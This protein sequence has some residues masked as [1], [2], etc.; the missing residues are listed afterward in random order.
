MLTVRHYLLDSL[1][2]KNN[3]KDYGKL[4]GSESRLSSTSEVTSYLTYT[5]DK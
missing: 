2:R 5:V 4:A 1:P 3:R